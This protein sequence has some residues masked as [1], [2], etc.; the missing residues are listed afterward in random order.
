MASFLLISNE[1]LIY[2][3]QPVIPDV[4]SCRL[5][6]LTSPISVGRPPTSPRSDG[7]ITLRLPKATDV[8]T[9]AP[10]VPLP[11]GRLS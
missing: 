5:V 9:R 4:C 6:A 7:V 11:F 8:A 2:F 1:Q 3:L 10:Y